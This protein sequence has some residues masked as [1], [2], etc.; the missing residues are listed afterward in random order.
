MGGLADSHVVK[1][2]LAVVAVSLICLVSCGSD[3]LD[4]CRED[5]DGT[6]YCQGV[7]LSN[8]DLSGRD[9]RNVNWSRPDHHFGFTDFSKANLSG[10]DFSDKYLR[11]TDFSG[12]NLEGADFSGSILEWVDFTGA[13]LSGTNFEHAHGHSLD[14]TGANLSGADFCVTDWSTWDFTGVMADAETKWP[15]AYGHPLRTFTKSR[16]GVVYEVFDNP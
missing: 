7:N 2:T 15:C 5:S 10:A 3:P 14:F 8:V 4:S 11:R 1:R 6:I 12:A 9:L 13:N 16:W